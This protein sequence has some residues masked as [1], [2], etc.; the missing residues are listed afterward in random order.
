MNTTL[1][2]LNALAV[3]ALVAFHFQTE[4]QPDPALVHVQAEQF[5]ARPA[6]QLADMKPHRGMPVLTSQQQQ[7][8]ATPVI[9]TERY[10]F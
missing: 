2:A 5:M 9:H 10:T 1:Y 8:E 7:G 3:V 6:A 4:K